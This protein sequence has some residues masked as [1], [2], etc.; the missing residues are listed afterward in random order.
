MTYLNKLLEPRSGTNL[1]PKAEW[2]PDILNGIRASASGT[3]MAVNTESSLKIAA[4]WACARLISEC[5]GMLPLVIYQRVGDRDRRRAT[6]HPLYDV[7]HDQP[8]SLQTAMSFKSQLTLHMLMRGNGRAKIMPGVRGFAD[9]LDPIHPDKVRVEEIDGGIRYVVTEKN[10][11]QV[12]YSDEQIF[13]VCGLSM[14]GINGMS[15]VS[16]A[17]ESFGLGLAMQRSAAKT[18]GNA[19]RMAGVLQVK[20]KLSKEA[21]VRMKASWDA[22][23]AGVER[24]GGTAVLEEGT[25]WKGISMSHKDSQWLEATEANAE[26]ICRW[27]G[28]PPHMIGLTS[29]T[30]SWGSGIEQMTIGFI[31]YTLM[32]WMTRWQQAISRDLIIATRQYFAEFVVEA[33]LRGDAL[34][35]YNVYRIGRELGMFNPNDLLRMENMNPRTDPDGDAYTTP[36][37]MQKSNAPSGAA[38]D[39]S[40]YDAILLESAGRVVRKEKAALAKAKGDLM[41]AASE[42]YSGHA[43]FVAQVMQIPVTYAQAYIREQLGDLAA[44][45]EA[46]MEDWETR[47]VSD[48]V[49]LAKESH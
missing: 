32:P 10:G 35:R 44:H 20:G 15:V 16:Y 26:E 34:T 11:R 7:L 28:V 8:N 27:F 33:L 14:D 30:T 3:G 5:I 42:F 9:Q 37:N 49:Q 38:T 13:D 23:N 40:H 36:L 24:T 46:A 41:E 17:R 12:N 47:R 1:Q 19:S 39:S 29:K 43:D 4:V 18:F 31:N 2:S 21:A 48:L 22:A 6:D 45:G 25:E